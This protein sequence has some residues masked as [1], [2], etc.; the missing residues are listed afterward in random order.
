MTN[1]LETV[2]AKIKEKCPEL[3]EWSFGCLVG[4]FIDHPLDRLIDD[5]GSVMHDGSI[6]N[7]K[8]LGY[9]IIGHEPRLEHLLIFINKHDTKTSTKAIEETI[10]RFTIEAIIGQDVVCLFTNYDLTK[11]VEDNLSSNEELLNFLF[12]LLTNQS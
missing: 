12:E 1:K 8:N 3:M 4:K 11:S 6:C 5:F 9:E 10:I 2:L 7:Y